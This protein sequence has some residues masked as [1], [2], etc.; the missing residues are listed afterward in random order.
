MNR[1]PEER[2][3]SNDA[4]ERQKESSDS[5]G[6]QIEDPAESKEWETGK[7]G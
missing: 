4:E 3:G 2:R 5:L 7:E 6:Q 1:D